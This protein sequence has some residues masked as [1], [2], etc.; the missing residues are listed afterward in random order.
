MA[1]MVKCLECNERF[2]R[3][4]IESVKVGGRYLHKECEKSFLEKKKKEEEKQKKVAKKKKTENDERIELMEYVMKL[5]GV[6]KPHGMLLKQM[7]EYR[8]MGYT[9]RGMLSTLKYFHETLNN[10]V[11]GDGI[12]IV[13]FVYEQAIEY[14][15]K[16]VRNERDY[17]NMKEKGIAPV[18]ITD[19]IVIR[20]IYRGNKKRKN[21][22]IGEMI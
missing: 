13:P 16:R 22:D 19:E 17:L 3:D 2:D 10:P 18:T 14:W 11:V 1:A 21:I 5:Q 4:K 20:P 8:E 9:Y 6:D 12:G 7:K 15:T